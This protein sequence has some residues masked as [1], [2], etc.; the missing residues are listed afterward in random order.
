MDSIGANYPVRWNHI[1]LNPKC[2]LPFTR[3]DPIGWTATST[4]Y[5]S[6]LHGAHF[7]GHKVSFPSNKRFAM[8]AA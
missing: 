8:T 2:A 3:M 6:E 5:K 1:D 7:T 4:V